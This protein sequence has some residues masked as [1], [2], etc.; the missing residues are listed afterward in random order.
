[1]LQRENPNLRKDLKIIAIAVGVAT[2]AALFLSYLFTAYDYE[3]RRVQ[4]LAN[5]AATDLSSL[6]YRAP[7]TWRFQE[8][9]LTELAFRAVHGGEAHQHDHEYRVVI[10]DSKGNQVLKLGSAPQFGEIVGTASIRDGNNIVGRL[11]FA[12]GAGDLWLRAVTPGIVGLVLGVVIFLVL[13]TM[14]MRALLRRDNQLRVNELQ[15]RQAQKMEAIGQLTGGIAHDFNNLLGIVIG[16][17]DFL[18]ESLDAKDER[19]KHADDAIGAALRGANLTH[20]LLAFARKQTLR[21]ELVNLND[22]VLRMTELFQRTLGQTIK[23]EPKLS[24]D[25]WRTQI[26]PA[27]FEEALLNLATNARHAMKD[28]GQLVI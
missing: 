5:N 12:E 20:R 15:L 24:N 7:E 26:D 11:T 13:Q 6:V 16:N 9:R 2:M 22:P 19:R 1:M 14:P 3:T 23:I 28:G 21:P 8:D 25:L 4:S 27:Q 18:Q 10:E 17:L